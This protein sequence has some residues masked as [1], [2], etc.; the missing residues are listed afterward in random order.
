MKKDKKIE[1]VRSKVRTSRC[2]MTLILG[3]IIAI[4]ITINA[5]CK[6][7]DDYLHLAARD[8]RRAQHL[9]HLLVATTV[10]VPDC[11]GG[12]G[13]IDGDECFT[14]FTQREIECYTGGVTV[15]A[16]WAQ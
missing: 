14:D 13:G 6:N 4:G 2:K 7:D 5:C 1:F 10:A 3:I 8:C 11:Q 12:N 9:Q 16:L 15:T